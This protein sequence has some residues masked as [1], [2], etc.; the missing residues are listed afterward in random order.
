MAKAVKYSYGDW[1]VESNGTNK[2]PKGFMFKQTDHVIFK[3]YTE[4][5][6]DT[7]LLCESEK[8]GTLY[9]TEM[10]LNTYPRIIDDTISGALCV[11]FVEQNGIPFVVL[12]QVKGRKYLTSAQGNWDSG[13]SLKEA[14]IRETREE[15]CLNVENLK[16]LAKAGMVKGGYYG[17]LRWNPV[18]SSGYFYGTAKC[19][20][21]WNLVDMVNKIGMKDDNEIEY[22]LVVNINSINEVEKVKRD[23][24]HETPLNGH[25]L[26]LIEEAIRRTYPEVPVSQRNI[27]KY[28][29]H[30][31][32]FEFIT[33]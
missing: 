25:H 18:V 31:K 26:V 29:K 2:L 24:I 4:Q 1:V 5:P 32:I 23:S 10:T 14:A 11:T 17:G 28:V 15:T 27:S 6:K 16:V 22:L 20:D 30:F 13:E 21:D 12:V 7:Q 3:G 9:C 19:P 33:D 8:Y